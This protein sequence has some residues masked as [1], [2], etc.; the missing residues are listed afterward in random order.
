MTFQA[1]SNLNSLTSKAANSD[2]PLHPRARG[3][4]SS[5]RTDNIVAMATQG[6]DGG[7]PSADF[8]AQAWYEL[9]DVRRVRKSRREALEAAFR[10]L[11]VRP[12]PW[13]G[14]AL[15]A[16]KGVTRTTKGHH[17]LYVLVYDGCGEDGLGL[18]VYVGRS[19]Y[20]PETRFAKHAAGTSES[21]S[22]RRFRLGRNGKRHRPIALLPS[23]F[24]HLNP[25][26]CEEAKRLE[27]ALVQALLAA[28]V[29]SSR[30]DGPRRY[31]T[32]KADHN[33]RE[34]TQNQNWRIAT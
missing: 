7:L 13:L 26:K 8:L 16:A 29:P 4:L 20:K 6:N 34:P 24:S 2:E 19:R 10:K 23:F 11:G 31:D 15:Q 18:G 17:H 21:K 12:E 32:K 27:V 3:S 25:L 5:V 33:M 28:G 30:V 1:T 9:V 14:A 22:A